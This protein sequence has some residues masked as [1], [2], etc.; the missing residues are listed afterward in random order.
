[1]SIRLIERDNLRRQYQAAKP[2]PWFCIDDFLESQFAEQV[3]QSFPSF[4]EAVKAGRLF[5]A[6][7]EK[8]K[9]QI[10]DSG[11]FPEPIARLNRELNGP[12]FLNLI[13][14]VTDTPNL[15]ADEQLV[16]GG[17]HETG[18]RGLLDVHLDFDYIPERQLYRRF[19]ILVYFNRNWRPDW[20]G[21]FELWNEDVTKLV[22]SFEPKFNRCLLFET[23]DR[24]WHGVNAVQCPAGQ[25]RKSFA[26]YYYTL[27]APPWFSGEHHSTLFKARPDEKLKGSV[28]MPAE[29][30]SRSLRGA[31]H[32]LKD[33]IRGR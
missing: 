17:I 18:P 2:V 19:N 6:V 15:L 13:E 1:M 28:L 7:N 10:T 27:A 31:Y 14:Y 4:D 29:K 5:S 26:A 22:H 21:Q 12:D 11:K 20:G 30:I 8:G 33:K 23:N 16:G 24:S 3:Y 32:G 9:V 25:S